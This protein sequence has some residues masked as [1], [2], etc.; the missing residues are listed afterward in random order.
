MTEQSADEDIVRR[1]LDAMEARALDAARALLGPGFRMTFPGGVRLETPE[2]LMA[3]ARPRYRFVRKRYER[4]DAMG[5]VVYC[6]GTLAGEWPDGT[7]FDGVRFI[8]RFEIKDGR[9][10]RQDV[11]NDLA[12]ARR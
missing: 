3:W 12:E 9:I 8:D 10:V 2:A 6:F 5:G 1:Y 7:P 11:W 4:F